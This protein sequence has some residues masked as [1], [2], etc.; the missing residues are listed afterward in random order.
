MVL[1]RIV[2]AYEV[3]SGILGLVFLI[4]PVTLPNAR[5]LTFNVFPVGLALAS[6]LLGVIT[7][8][9]IPVGR[10]LSMLFQL[11]FSIERCVSITY[12]DGHCA[13]EMSPWNAASPR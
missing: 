6:V 2:A 9:G 12:N 7:W 1:I 5:A 8:V 4:Q 3:L 10:R 11:S 13:S